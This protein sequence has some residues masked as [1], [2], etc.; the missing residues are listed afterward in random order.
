MIE[1]CPSTSYFVLNLRSY[2]D[3]PYIRKF[4][5][6]HQPISLNTDDTAIFNTTL[7]KEILHI[8]YALDWEPKDIAI[9]QARALPFIFASPKEKA[10]ITH[11]FWSEL[12][13]LQQLLSEQQLK[14]DESDRF[15]GHEKQGNLLENISEESIKNEIVDT[16]ENMR[17]RL[18][19]SSLEVF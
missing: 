9:L 17:G 4:H 12:A 6:M 10:E 15:S 1:I 13:R 14:R 16:S 11:R 2:A 8:M 19:A 7:T 5:S 3:H 18:I